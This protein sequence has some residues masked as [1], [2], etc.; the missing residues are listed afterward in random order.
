[1]QDNRISI[2]PSATLAAFALLLVVGTSAVAQQETILYSFGSQPKDGS[3]P[4]AG[5]IFDGDGNLYGTTETGGSEN[6]GTVFELTPAGG[7]G[8]TE[9]ILHFFNNKGAAAQPRSGLIFDAAGNLYGTAF[10]GGD[11]NH[12]GAVFELIPQAGGGWT[13]QILHAFNGRNGSNSAA[14]LIFDAAGNLYGT[15]SGGGIHN[16]GT[17]FELMPVTGGGWTEKVLHNF[18]SS[19]KDGY[20]PFGSLIFDAAG[21]LY[22]TTVY[23]GDRN[24]CGGL[25]CGIVF[26]LKPVAGGGWTEKILHTF[27]GTDGSA[28]IAGMVF[29]TAGNLYGTTTAGGAGSCGTVFEL[30][31]RAAGGWTEKVLLNF[32]LNGKAGNTP[33]S[34]LIFD[35]AGNLYGTTVHNGSGGYGTVFE[36]TRAAHG[37]WPLKVLHGF[38]FN[39]T[40]GTEPYAGLIF[41]SAGNL[42]GTTSGGG[43][44]DSGTVFEI[45]P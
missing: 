2:R 14:T 45:T 1:M 32:N 21:N 25:G 40:D 18:N 34:N 41:D 13:N 5:V 28:P 4:N 17:V 20:S 19:G 33:W 9:T 26:E 29:D 39:G 6:G 44:H 3:K 30:K 31:P 7:G 42:Y 22:G 8:W 12:D 11:A 24:K 27:I 16:N 15:T 37:Q 36:L 10:Y 23:G 38:S 35:A 43:A